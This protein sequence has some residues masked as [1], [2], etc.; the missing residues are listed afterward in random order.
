MFSSELY[1]KYI[2]VANE[3]YSLE[4]KINDYIEKWKN[5]ETVLSTKSVEQAIEKGYER[6]EDLKKIEESIHQDFV[7]MSALEEQKQAADIGIRST[8]GQAPTNMSIVD[9]VISSN[10]SESHLIA[11]KKS[12]EQMASEKRQMLSEL[13]EKVRN[14]EITLAQA[15]ELSAKINSS[16]DFYGKE[17]EIQVRHRYVLKVGHH[18]SKT[19]SSKEFINEINPN[20]SIISVGKNNIYGHPNKEVLN[21]L[22][23]SKI[24]RIDQDGSIMYKIKNNKLKIETCT[25]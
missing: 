8:L 17:E 22:E 10:A 5:G 9:G 2:E 21:T 14:G 7:Q 24:Y 6:L 19:S 20:Y 13:K 16:F 4:N 15:S 23:D 12:D 25:Q 18:G 11:E 3:R 1:K